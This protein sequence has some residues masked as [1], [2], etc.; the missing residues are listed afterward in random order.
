MG[1]RRGPGPFRSPLRSLPVP[2]GPPPVPIPPHRCP[3]LPPRNGGAAPTAAAPPRPGCGR[4]ARPCGLS[5]RR[6][7]SLTDSAPSQSERGEGWGGGAKRGKGKRTV[8]AVRFPWGGRSRL[9]LVLIGGEESG[10]SSG[11]ALIGQS[12]ARCG[13]QP[14]ALGLGP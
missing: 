7:Q 10:D 4:G 2:S 1:S 14:L 8:L 13:L 12:R 9:L 3:A 5:N 11:R 6:S